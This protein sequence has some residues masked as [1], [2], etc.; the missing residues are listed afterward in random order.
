VCDTMGNIILTS[1]L[2]PV[3]RF[4]FVPNNNEPPCDFLVSPAS[5]EICVGESVVLSAND[6]ATNY[7]WS[8][9]IGLSSSNE[10]EVIASPL[11]T[12][13]YTIT[14][15][16][17]ECESIQ[18]VTITVNPVSELAITQDPENAFLCSGPITLS[19]SSSFSNIEWSNGINDVSS[20]EI[21][22]PGT[23]SVTATNEFDCLSSSP[24]ITIEQGT[25]PEVNISPSGDLFLCNGNVVLTANSG[26]N[27]YVWSNGATGNSIEV[28][29][30]GE[31]QV[32][33]QNNDECLGQS[34]IVIVNPSYEVDVEIT[35][36][37]TSICAG[38]PVTISTDQTFANYQWSNGGTNISISV[39]QSGDYSLTVTD[40]NGCTGTSETIS[41]EIVELPIAGFTY[42]QTNGYMVD[43]SNT[44]SGGITFFWN[45]SGGNSSTQENPSFTYPFEGF[46]PVTLI[47][48]NDCG[49][50]TIV[51]SIEVLKLSTGLNPETS[52]WTVFPNPFNDILTIHPNKIINEDISIN[53]LNVLG[54]EVYKSIYFSGN[55][56]PI[57]IP[58]KSFSTGVY[59]IRL[60]TKNGLSSY[61]IV[62]HYF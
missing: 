12:T 2:K 44:S 54:Q 36:P 23:Y 50:D 19:I 5:P 21:N 33:A 34:N 49:S 27:T 37:T 35:A 4:G 26:L 1:N 14:G 11:E 13:T 57:N 41:I 3:T 30:P 47:V 16:T 22:T 48:T 18:T 56:S 29:T 31:Y 38:N 59:F 42:E 40:E 52:G 28:N 45:F 32:S 51:V 25:I 53:I 8:P 46:Y 62:K 61:K 43:F 6:G 20:I 55:Q 39:N 7:S 17:G 58:V 15:T 9:S 24:E 10:A 60:E